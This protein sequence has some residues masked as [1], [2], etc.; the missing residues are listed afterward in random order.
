MTCKTPAFLVTSWSTWTVQTEVMVLQIRNKNDVRNHVCL[1]NKREMRNTFPKQRLLTIMAFPLFIFQSTTPSS[2][3]LLWFVAKAFFFPYKPFPEHLSPYPHNIYF[4]SSLAE[5]ENLTLFFRLRVPLTMLRG[6][7]DL[8][9]L[10]FA[11]ENRLRGKRRRPFVQAVRPTHKLDR[12]AEPRK[13]ER[14]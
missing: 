1:R 13:S 9:R 5:C 14:K 2:Y 11:R 4:L 7:L 10:A 12:T 8:G 6:I 3:S